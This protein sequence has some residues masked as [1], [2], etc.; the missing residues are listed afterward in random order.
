MLFQTELLFMIMDTLIDLRGYG[1]EGPEKQL[2][3]RYR[4][5]PESPQYFEAYFFIKY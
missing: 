5:Y 4:C 2:L 3:T 1:Y